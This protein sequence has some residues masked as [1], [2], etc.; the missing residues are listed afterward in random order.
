M[1]EEKKKEIKSKMS[2]LL[3]DDKI[4]KIIII[5]G[6]CGIA[7]IFI[8]NFMS[9]NS[10]KSGDQSSSISAELS[11]DGLDE[12]KKSIEDRLSNIISKIDGAGKTD[13]FLTLENGSENVYAVNRKQNTSSDSSGTADESFDAEYF[14]VRKSDGSEEGV[15][16]KVIEPDVRGVVVV[17]DGGDNSVVKEKV[18][19]SVTK[20]LNISSAR[21]CISKLSQQMEE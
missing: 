1:N 19:E 21:V 16:L 9:C 15:L 11:Y 7:L 10:E 20:S 5:L 6:L 18:L 8:S 2:D 12:Y 4:K 13:V 3:K 17:C 14:S